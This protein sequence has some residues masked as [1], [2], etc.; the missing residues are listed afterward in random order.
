M[1]AFRRRILFLALFS[2]AARAER[3]PV[4]RLGVA[5]GLAEETVTAL[6]RDSRGFLWIGSL[7]GLSRFDGERFKVYGLTD[8]LPRLRILG[9]AEG[10]D[11]AVWVA[12]GGGL[13][14]LDPDQLSTKPVFRPAAAAEA[15]GRAV[16]HVFVDRSGSVWFG[17]GGE[18]WRLGPGGAAAAGLARAA[19]GAAAIRAIREAADGTLWIGTSQGLVRLRPP[20]GPEREPLPG[21]RSAPD[22]RGLWLDRSG[23]LWATTPE[24]LYVFRPGPGGALS[25]R[26]RP[27]LRNGHVAI[28]AAEGEVAVL[29]GIPGAPK[30]QWQKPLE[31]RE[32]RI[33]LSSTS[34][35][36]VLEGG[37]LQRYGRAE[38]L[39]DGILGELLEGAE[40]TVWI[41][42]QS[43]G[44]L[45]LSPSGFSSFGEA[46][47]LPDPRVATLFSDGTRRVYASS[48]G[49]AILSL[50]DGTA[51][52][53]VHL[54]PET[55]SPSR[56]L[57]GR[58]VLHAR[59]GAWWV[60]TPAGLLRYGAAPFGDALARRRPLA[61]YTPRDGLGGTEVSALFEDSRGAIWA[62]V[63]DSDR[64]LARLEPGSGRFEP[65]G[66]GDGLPAAAPL[67]FLEEGPDLW[68][69]CGP[70][71]VVR[72]RDGRFT[73]LGPADGVPEGFAHD[74]LLDGAGR[75]WIANGS[76]GAVRLDAPSA[77]RPSAVKVPPSEEPATG[78]VY[79]LAEDAARFIYFGTSRGVDRLDPGSG[80]YRH[81]TTAD[82]LSNNVVTSAVVDGAGAIWFGTPGGVSRLVPA[83][84][85]PGEPPG[86]VIMSVRVNGNPRPVPELGARALPELSMAPDETRLRI[87]FAAPSFRPGEK[88]RFQ[89]RLFGA[90]GVWSVPSAEPTVRYVGLPPGRYRF[91][92][93]ALTGADEPG[94]EATLAIR[95]QPPVWRQ[96]WF[97]LLLG[98][99]AVLAGLVVH[100]QSLKRAVSLERVR[101]RLATDLHDDVG[102]SLARISILS[103]VG[104]RSVEEGS[105]AARLFDQVGETSR[106]VIDALG[107]AIWS[108]DPRRDDVQSVADRLRLFAA[109]LLEGR[110]IALRLG[111]PPE[112]ARV[113]LPS[114]TR[115]HLFLLLKEAVTNA[116]RHSGAATVEIDLRVAGRTLEVEVRDDGAGFRPPGPGEAREGRGL[117]NMAERAAALGARLDVRAEPGAGT[118][119]LLTG[120]A[121]PGA[122]GLPRA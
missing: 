122:S 112:A 103:E 105:E 70:G 52:V 5:E 111:L 23:L 96:V 86:A 4:Q 89:T 16:E 21:T 34:G 102:S 45:R 64:P 38:G 76:G 56:L 78:S 101:T 97:L 51:F 6:L 44:L 114:E 107:D 17:S 82:G 7:N 58:S 87:D 115:R 75:L 59:S 60:G 3:L 72:R 62:G 1:T 50:F 93:R 10:R 9:L 26:P 66:V 104:R 37:R 30:A 49:N 41:G 67:A 48:A 46:D 79:A 74:L 71:G 98:A 36:V 42:T 117:A 80:R 91:A 8:G 12:T 118:R 108:I 85:A 33:F 109:D 95:M 120:V 22:V 35:L 77:A 90:E 40:G 20:G 15:S 69:A 113:E 61:V 119:I 73:R 27:L 14:H 11:G 53:S 63:Y 13:V 65:F 32:G 84:E 110:G 2:A 121:L 19:P 57:W 28:P 81:F 100:R 88:V 43:T 116:A 47:G 106:A 55:P 24:A 54:R 31:T 99:L 25:S 92:V 68:I 94:A 18:L 29:G 39:G 83:R